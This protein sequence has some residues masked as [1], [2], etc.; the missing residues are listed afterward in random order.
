MSLLSYQQFLLESYGEV[1]LSHVRKRF[2]S[3]TSKKVLGWKDR[4]LFESVLDL[5][6]TE[7][8][9]EAIESDNYES[10]Y[11]SIALNE[12]SLFAKFKEKAKEGF[13]KAKE[14][15]AKAK[16]KL[17]DA[18]KATMKFA[19]DL[20][21]PIKMVLQKIAE[22]IKQV[23]EKGKELAAQSLNAVKGKLEERIKSIIK[24]GEK[25][26]SLL[27]EA[28]N[29][30]QMASA[31]A[32]WITGGFVESMGKSAATAAKTEESFYMNYV[33]AAVLEETIK[34]IEGLSRDE[35]SRQLNEG[36]G[37]GKEGGLNIPFI[38]AV[39]KKLGHLPPFK[40]FHDLGS[41]VE[42]KVNDGLNRMSAVLSK[43]AS[44]PG[45]FNFYIVGGLVGVVVGYYAENFAK[46]AVKMGLHA[47]E[48][49]LGIAIPGAG[50]VF[51]IIKY[52]G[53][54]L[55]VYGIIE[56]LAGQGEKEK[57][58]ETSGEDSS[59]E[60]KPKEATA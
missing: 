9:F 35:I 58:G 5:G 54:G 6:Y 40:Y 19:G 22:G 45:P 29:M 38:S 50:I 48:H 4:A 1:K 47:L 43:I 53:I 17:S 60:E 7:Q 24:D 41:K 2:L 52:C 27:E 18:T 11:E 34:Q 3:E 56:Q 15:G 26:K 57:K 25:K 31:G 23:W 36:G 42:V 30:K 51:S 13:E 44:A 14:L 37:H 21:K 33:E 8:I 10:L 39:F 55:L 46:S 32:G 16:E 28:K 59:K 12:E 20:L 49:A